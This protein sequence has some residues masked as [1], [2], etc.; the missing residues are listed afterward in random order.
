MRPYVV[1][2]LLVHAVRFFCPNHL[3]AKIKFV[4]IAIV[5]ENLHGF[6][7]AAHL[8]VMVNIGRW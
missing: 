6:W 7:L 5:S 1:C 2:V 4:D 3:N 8:L